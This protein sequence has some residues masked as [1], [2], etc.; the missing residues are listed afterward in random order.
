MVSSDRRIMAN[1]VVGGVSRRACDNCV[2]K[3][4]R[5]YCAGDDAFLCQSC[6]A[7][8]HSANSLARRH[9]RVRLTT[10]TTT[11]M[12]SMMIRSISSDDDDDDDEDEDEQLHMSGVA[13]PSWHHGVTR[14][15]RTPKLKKHTSSSSEELQLPASSRIHHSSS[16]RVPEVVCSSEEYSYYCGDEQQLL[17]QVPVL[18]NHTN[19][20][21]PGPDEE[22]AIGPGPVFGLQ[23]M[24]VAGFGAVDFESLFGGDPEDEW[25]DFD[26]ESDIKGLGVSETELESRKLQ[27]SIINEGAVKVGEGNDMMSDAAASSEFDLHATLVERGATLINN[28]YKGSCDEDEDDDIKMMMSKQIC[29]SLRLD[30]RGVLSAWDGRKSPW[31][32]GERPAEADY[33][34]RLSSTIDQCSSWPLCLQVRGICGSSDVGCRGQRE[35]EARVMRYRDKRRT[36]LFSKKIRYQVRKLNA[37]KRPRIKG[38]FVKTPSLIN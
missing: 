28:N 21:G 2:R 37:E 31:M 34:L 22:I 27:L 14:K 29:I 32:T 7:S 33:D 11:T 24:N 17:H 15:A 5:W 23:E 10:T 35:R 13:V 6:D 9:E 30:Y 38:R 16:L 8:V 19:Q 1:V 18:S 3:R 20:L 4:A 12:G 26:F 25:F 36:R